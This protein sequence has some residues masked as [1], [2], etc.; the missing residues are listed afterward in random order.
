MSLISSLTQL[1]DAANNRLAMKMLHIS[2]TAVAK[3]SLTTATHSPDSRI[4][5]ASELRRCR[6]HIPS[7]ITRSLPH[8]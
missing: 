2:S 3:C 4:P 7:A 8:A 5:M 6:N 1:Q